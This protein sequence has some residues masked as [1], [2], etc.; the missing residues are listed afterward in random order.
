MSQAVN[1]AEHWDEQDTTFKIEEVNA[2]E[3]VKV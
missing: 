2:L 1:T 3:R